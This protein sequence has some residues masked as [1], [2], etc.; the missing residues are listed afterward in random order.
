MTPDK[1]RAV[2]VG[3]LGMAALFAIFRLAASRTAKQNMELATQLNLAR[4]QQQEE[5]EARL[6]EITRARRRSEDRMRLSLHGRGTWL[7]DPIS[8]PSIT[9]MSR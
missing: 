3:A 1:I 4:R 2:G 5:A 8:Q 7:Y 9:S 6:D